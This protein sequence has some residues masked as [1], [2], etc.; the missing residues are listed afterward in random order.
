MSR[1]GGHGQFKVGCVVPPNP[2]GILP[3]GRMGVDACEL[4][5]DCMG[6]CKG[7]FGMCGM[8]LAWRGSH[9][10]PLSGLGNSRWAKWG[11]A[12]QDHRDFARGP[13]G[14]GCLRISSGLHGCMKGGIW[15]VRHASGMEGQPWHP[16]QWPWEIPVGKMGL[17]SCAKG[18]QIVATAF[19]E[20]RPCRNNHG[21]LGMTCRVA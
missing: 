19:K 20:G 18:H 4:V 5:R 3:E 10:S 21:C 11:C 6:A 12:H 8:L 7:A 17:R 16:P 15:H 2:N 14:G 1:L 9:G 13:N